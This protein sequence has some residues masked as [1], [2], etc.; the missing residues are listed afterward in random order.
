MK[1][2]YGIGISVTG[3]LFILSLLTGNSLI[4]TACLTA[5]VIAVAIECLK[6]FKGQHVISTMFD[7]TQNRAKES[8]KEKKFG[9]AMVNFLAGPMVI[10]G[11]IFV[12]IIL[13]IMWTGALG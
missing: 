6:M 7:H 3:V 5:F 10:I 4:L 8:L 11:L 13:I 9:T 1:N 2:K 12:V